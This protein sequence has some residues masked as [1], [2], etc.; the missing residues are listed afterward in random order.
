MLTET[1]ALWR[2]LLGTSWLDVGNAWRNLFLLSCALQALALGTAF[3]LHGWWTR[4]SRF[5]CFWTGAAAT[6]F[7]QYLWT[8]ALAALWPHAPKLVYIGVL[9]AL[10]GVYLLGALLVHRQALRPALV[11]GLAFGKRLCTFDKPALVSLCFALALAALLL[12]MTVRLC[13]SM[14]AANP[15]DSGEYM[16]LALRYTETRDLGQLL[17]KE[18][19]TGKFRGNSH[20]PSLELYMVQGLMH[21]GGESFG[22]PSD[23]PML[24]GIGLLNFYMI[25]AFL[26]LLTVLCHQRKRWVLL[27]ALLFNLVPNLFDSMASAPRDIWRMLALLL[28][29]LYFAGL[30][31]RGTWKSYL[32]KLLCTAVICFAVM[33]AHVVCFVVLPFI[34]VAWVLAAWVQLALEGKGLQLRGLCASV[35][36]AL[37]GALGTLAGFAGNLWCY[38]KW[39]EMSPWRLM[40]T[41][42]SAP[43]Y[44]AYMAGEYKLEETTTHLNFFADWQGMVYGH[45]TPVGVWGVRLALVGLGCVLA[46]L[47]WRKR[48]RRR[49]LGAGGSAQDH[50]AATGIQVASR[51][52]FAALLTLCT[53]AP[54]TGLL[55]SK[56]YSFS[57]SFAALPRYTLQWFLWAAVMIC[58]LLA[59]LEA[60]WPAFC[61]WANSKLSRVRAA[62]W[63]D[64]PWIQAAWRNLPALLCTGLCLLAF[65]QGTSQTGY[66][67]SI[68]RSSRNVMEDPQ[69]LLDNGFLERN[70]LLM[71]AAKHVGEDQKILIT[72]SGYQYPLRAKAYVLNSNPMVPLMNL[73]AAEVPA[74]LAELN[75]AMLATE[76]DFWDD[77]YFGLST[78][79]EVLRALPP[80]QIVQDEHMRLYLL[81]PALAKDIR[82]EWEGVKARTEKGK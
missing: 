10:A 25:G 5:A 50:A 38:F 33:S 74:A 26:A 15:A 73:P 17:D 27:G 77:R 64:I 44:S 49:G 30:S 82:A 3:A 78:L 66:T 31:P 34:V 70:G 16:G 53:L 51:L 9:P 71:T 19:A 48:S 13:G 41:Y 1:A 4:K 61:Q 18:E 76:P 40:T 8:L 29:S 59:S 37:F 11:R 54:M 63:R 39:G 69:L 56:L 65:A 14:N 24:F 36:I 7:L 12:P 80:E 42:T 55:D 20:F 81:D 47:L 67:E 57:G 45:A 72:R 60:V 62:R 58:S 68:Y 32:G 23:K 46:A 21:T 75:V 43:W 6:P 79:A 28:A 22:Y 35:G 52:G 2:D